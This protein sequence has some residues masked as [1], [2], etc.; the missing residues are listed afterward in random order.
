M[1][2]QDKNGS[3]EEKECYEAAENSDNRQ[4]IDEAVGDVQCRG[5]DQVVISK[6]EYENLK[7]LAEESEDYLQRLRRSIADNMNLQKRIEKVRQRA[8]YESLREL[9]RKIVPLADSLSRALENAE[10]YDASETIYEGLKLTEKEFYDI[11]HDLHIQPIEAEGMSFD[12]DYHDAVFQQPTS[13]IE[14]NTVINEIKKGF[15]IEG[16]L[17]R[18]SQVV[19]AKELPDKGEKSEEI[20]DDPNRN[21]ADQ[22]NETQ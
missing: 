21:S 6:D 7:K 18:P 1:I 3:E 20:S 12:P 16:D 14:P 5:D 13:E 9:G 8:R 4:D 22:S 17:L 11:L 19:V 15:L 10:K 2:K